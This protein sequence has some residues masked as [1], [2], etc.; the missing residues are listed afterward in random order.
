MERGV[1]GFERC[2]SKVVPGDV[3]SWFWLT[4]VCPELVTVYHSWQNNTEKR[5]PHKLV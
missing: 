2:G 4:Q 1:R 5:H 3:S